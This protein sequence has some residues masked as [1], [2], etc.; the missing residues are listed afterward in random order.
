MAGVQELL[1][2]LEER[3]ARELGIAR[4]KARR[5][6]EIL[7]QEATLDYLG[8]AGSGAVD[9]YLL[10]LRGRAA[11]EEERK[12]I[13]IVF[14]IKNIGVAALGAFFD[15]PGLRGASIHAAGQLASIL[16][17]TVLEHLGR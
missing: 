3:V 14:T 4:E 17:Q 15:A 10:H 9:G 5:L 2:P 13:D 1:E 6:V 16:T 12:R 8:A 11:T 7:R